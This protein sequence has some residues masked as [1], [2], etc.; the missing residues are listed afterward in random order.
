[1]NWIRE[2]IRV[3]DISR[4]GTGGVQGSTG[5]ENDG[6][7][8]GVVLNHWVNDQ[9]VYYTKATER[10][11]RKLRRQERLSSFFY[12]LGL[13]LAVAML[14]FHNYLHEFELIHHAMVVSIAMALALAAALQGHIEKAALSEHVKQ[15]ERMRDL[16]TFAS[17]RLEDFLKEGKLSEAR[18]LIAH[19]GEESLRENGDW[20]LLHRSRPIGVPKG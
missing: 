7:V 5:I 14:I 16:F 13:G 18:H 20:V 8:Y 4:S 17:H 12:W 1:M 19:L 11:E 10:D 6:E 3:T 9:A 2:A 15:Y